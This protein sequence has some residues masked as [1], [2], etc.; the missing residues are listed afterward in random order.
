MY[1]SRR[2]SHHW[3]MARLTL[4]HVMETSSNEAEVRHI[5]PLV[6]SI[7][8]IDIRP[9][10]FHCN[11]HD[12]QKSEYFKTS[13]SHLLVTFK[14][15]PRITGP[16]SHRS[17]HRRI[18][19]LRPWYVDAGTRSSQRNCGETRPPTSGLRTTMFMSPS[20]VSNGCSLGRVHRHEN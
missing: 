4:P 11:C 17:S 16:S 10:P 7:R 5:S 20:S 13:W 19:V 6:Y 8:E 12:A 15:L 14:L 9:F 2:H 1:T 18:S 3:R